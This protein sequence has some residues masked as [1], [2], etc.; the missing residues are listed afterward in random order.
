MI[1][2]LFRDWVVGLMMALS[3]A[4]FAIGEKPYAIREGDVVF[5]SSSAGQGGA[6]ILATRSPYSHCGVVFEDAGKMMVL[7]AVQPVGMVSLETFMSRSK[8]GTFMARRLKT[9]ITPDHYRAARIWAL[10]QI[11]KNYD[12]RF[13][14]DDSNLYCSELVWKIYHRAGVQLCEPRRFG[15]YDLEDP[16]VKEIIKER[17]GDLQAL[18]KDE[19]VV[20]PSDLATSS[21]LEEVPRES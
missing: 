5:S 14:W 19:K 4:V 16:S 3:P 10:Q 11:G 6:I 21:L 9:P 8:P 17:Y 2:S 13:L 12:G 18:P 15:D 20:A 7:E 1:R